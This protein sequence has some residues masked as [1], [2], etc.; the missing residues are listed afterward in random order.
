VA[1]KKTPLQ[2][3]KVKAEKDFKKWVKDRDNWTCQLCGQSKEDGKVIQWSHFWPCGDWNVRFDPENVDA[4]CKGC[5]FEH[6]H[7][8]QGVYRDWKINQLGREA[9]DTLEERSKISVSHWIAL[10]QAGEVVHGDR[11]YYYGGE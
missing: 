10:E 5:H 3:A 2:K 8:K 7:K 4:F 11:D 6:E 1:K 9:Y